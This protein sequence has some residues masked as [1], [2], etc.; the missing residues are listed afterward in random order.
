MY[1]VGNTFC[2]SKCSS[3]AGSTSY[4]IT[5]RHDMILCCLSA[6]P[7]VL[8]TATPKERQRHS[9][10]CN[11]V[12]TTLGQRV[13]QYNVLVEEYNKNLEPPS[14]TQSAP[15]HAAAPLPD[16]LPWNQRRATTTLEAVR[17][18]EFS[19]RDEYSCESCGGIARRLSPQ[20]LWAG[21]LAAMNNC[22]GLHTLSASA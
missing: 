18:Q 11:E 2:S 12:V 1:I 19:W 10:K 4:L 17:K 7:L 14:A 15:P 5:R 22:Y 16:V 9:Q 20:L 21:V 6:L 13:Q 8:P 3:G